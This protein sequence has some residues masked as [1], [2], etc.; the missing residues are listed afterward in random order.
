[1]PSEKHINTSRTEGAFSSRLLRP[2]IR[3]KATNMMG[4]CGVSK[5]LIVNDFIYTQCKL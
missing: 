1:M 5:I 4:I 3:I 2:G